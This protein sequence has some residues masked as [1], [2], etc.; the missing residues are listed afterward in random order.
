MYIPFS[1]LPVPTSSANAEIQVMQN[2]ENNC[3]KIS[4][5]SEKTD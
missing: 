1:K 3:E 4:D 2:I 5:N